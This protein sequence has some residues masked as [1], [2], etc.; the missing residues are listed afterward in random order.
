MRET[1]KDPEIAIGGLDAD[2]EHPDF[3]RDCRLIY[4][5]F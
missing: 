5:T 2:T 1:V 4:A 3:D